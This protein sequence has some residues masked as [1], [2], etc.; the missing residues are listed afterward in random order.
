M[1]KKIRVSTSCDS[2][3]CLVSHVAA[4]RSRGK[5]CVEPHTVLTTL[6]LNRHRIGVEG[7]EISVLAVL[8]GNVMHDEI[9][10]CSH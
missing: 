4:D 5:G 10:R 1:A 8:P 7:G 2:R 3:G 9:T 6:A